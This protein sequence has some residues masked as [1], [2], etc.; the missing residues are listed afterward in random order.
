VQIFII[1]ALGV[2]ITLISSKIFSSP[3]QRAIALFIWHT[4][5][6]FVYVWY[7]SKFGGDAIYYYDEA[8]NGNYSFGPSTPFI[9][10]IS[11]F[12]YDFA[13]LSFFSM[14]VLFGI[15]GI[16]GLLAFDA[17]LR[18]VTKDAPKKIKLLATIIVFMPSVSF[19]SSGLG[20]DSIV[21]TAINLILWASLNLNKRKLI[22]IFGIISL[23]LVRP[24]IA[25][26]LLLTFSAAILA[27]K[28]LK[29]SIR[30]IYFFIL[31][32]ASIL[33][34]PVALEITDFKEDLTLE[35]IM[36]YLEGRQES[37]WQ[38]W[39]GGIDISSMSLPVQIFTYLFRPLP[40]ESHN[41]FS[42][43]VSLENVFLIYFFAIGLFSKFYG[44][45][46][47]AHPQLY[48]SF[49]LLY[50][51]TALILLSMTTPN[52]GISVRQKWMFLPFFIVL[53]ISYIVQSIA[54]RKKKRIF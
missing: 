15:F 32:I 44:R 7:V 41:I 5:F 24:H 46:V 45:R 36:Y 35:N 47:S 53:F 18:C 39:D 27:A 49:F 37:N 12:F 16:I 31:V 22:L 40:F 19:W 4:F 48:S 33:I 20:K 54:Q 6:S 52:F 1:L 34:V 43:L 28:N 21:F 2:V 42:L 30:I 13:N 26:L 50:S 14:G 23:L 38:G 8:Q 9:V 10:F 29:V 3:P 11:T 25:V 51:V 17:S